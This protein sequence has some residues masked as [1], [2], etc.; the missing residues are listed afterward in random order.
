MRFTNNIE[1]DFKYKYFFNNL[2]V[3]TYNNKEGRIQTP[4]K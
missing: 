1:M 2:I 3:T 4:N